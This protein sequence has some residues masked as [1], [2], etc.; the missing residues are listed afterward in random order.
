M[1][2]DG[3]LDGC[4]DGRMDRWTD[5][6]MNKQ[7]WTDRQMDKADELTINGHNRCMTSV[8]NQFV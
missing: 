6:R 5:G 2:N 1:G 7:I 8:A 3:W 4:M